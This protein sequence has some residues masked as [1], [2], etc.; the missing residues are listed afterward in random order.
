MTPGIVTPVSGSDSTEVSSYTFVM[1]PL[2]IDDRSLVLVLTGAG[3]SAE[4]GIP[5]FRDAKGLWES[6]RFEDVASPQGFSRD[7]QL[8]W[9]FY[10]ERRRGVLQAKPNTGHQA[11]ATLEA[12][13]GDR[14]LLVTQNVDGLHQRAGS[15][16]VLEI[17]GNL[18]KTR[19]SRCTREPFDDVNLYDVGKLPM[20]SRCRTAGKES[21]L[22]PH[23][24]WFGE[25]LETSTL[26][27]INAFVTA[28]DANL[29]FVAVGTSGAVYPAA[30]LVDAARAVG[31]QS[32]LVNLERAD[33]SQSFDH[34]ILGKSG[35]ILPALLQS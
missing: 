15:T 16:R 33:N 6:H 21:L 8:V 2:A 1:K 11:L 20:C 22:R 25:A 23:I 9:R 3:V 31:G 26:E 7:P 18:L 17:H 5:T 10:S 35:E 32:Y 19:C 12:R 13:L 27:R 30:A 28:A 29:I 14:M 4:S 34:V 24:V